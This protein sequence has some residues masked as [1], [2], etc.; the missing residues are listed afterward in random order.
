MAE[1]FC[2]GLSDFEEYLE[3][4]SDVLES[5]NAVT[6]LVYIV[7]EYAPLVVSAEWVENTSAHLAEMWNEHFSDEYGS[8]DGESP[9]NPAGQGSVQEMEALLTGWAKRA[10]VWRCEPTGRSFTVEAQED[11]GYVILF[12]VG[13][14]YAD[15]RQPTLGL[16]DEVHTDV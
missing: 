7:E 1:Q 13:P 3:S 9:D 4:I 2:Y 6:G 14:P 11:G 10:R 12:T 16:V 5:V 15:G 8:L